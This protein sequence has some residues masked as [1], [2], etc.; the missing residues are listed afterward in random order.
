[1]GYDWDFS[2]FVPYAGALWRGTLLTLQLSGVGSIVGTI[3]GIP[4]AVFLRARP[5]GTV[6]VLANDMVR[7]IPILV[8]MFFF[9]Y[10]PYEALLGIPSP[11]AYGS[12]MLALVVAQAAF[13]GDIIRGAIDGVSEKSIAG[14]RALGLREGAIWRLI[15]LPDVFRQI[16]PTLMAFYIGNVRLS[17][18]ASVIGTHEV[19]YVARV[20]IGQRARSLEAWLLVG[21]IYVVLVVPLAWAARRLERTSW[22]R[23][24]DA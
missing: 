2:P 3:L 4:V 22:A 19:V 14:A 10:F 6:F 20:A 18:I 21:A 1:M 16:L 8:L 11:S 12:A 7:A 17:S 5:L 23:R 13:T 24:R 9:Y 15:V